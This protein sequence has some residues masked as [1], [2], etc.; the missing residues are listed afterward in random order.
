MEK[1]IDQYLGKLEVLEDGI[2]EDIEALLTSIEIKEVMENP[3][4]VF[5]RIIEEIEKR[6]KEDYHTDAF[7]IG[8][9]FA[10][11]IKENV[12]SKNNSAV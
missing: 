8:Q 3:L 2:D 10:G 9:R 11:D 1:S 6:L 7:L 5:G 12:Q 4:A